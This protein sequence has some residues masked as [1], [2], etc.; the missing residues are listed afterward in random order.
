MSDFYAVKKGDNLTK[1][2][3]QYN[4]T[5]KE[6]LKLNPNLKKGGNLIFVGDKI[7]LPA[8]SI[9]DID[10]NIP[11]LSLERHK[12]ELSQ[13]KPVEEKQI[14]KAKKPAPVQPKQ[15]APAI[16]T[17]KMPEPKKLQQGE[18]A[19]VK[20][21]LS[22]KVNKNF[23]VRTPFLGSAEDLE[24]ILKNT[25]LR[26]QGEN[27]LAAQEKYGVNA[28]FMVAISRTESS[29]GKHISFGGRYGKGNFVGLKIPNIRTF[30]ECIDKLGDTIANGKYYYRQN[31]TTIGQIAPTYCDYRWG[32]DTTKYMD[33]ARRDILNTNYNG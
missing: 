3:K 2:A 33:I 31:K 14:A 16:I 28:L 32:D 18:Y 19:S 1:I 6:L 9:D 21:S 4:T 30:E 20:D 12:K 22:Q 13:D 25:P 11:G 7:N 8:K 26:G 27:F 5:V 17:P 24:V 15:P 29:F 10:M 23:D